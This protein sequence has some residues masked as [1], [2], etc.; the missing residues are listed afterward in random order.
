MVFSPPPRGLRVV[1]AFVAAALAAEPALASCPSGVDADGDGYPAGFVPGSDLD[2][3]DDSANGAGSWLGVST[4][5]GGTWRADL[6][7]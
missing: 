5:G 4:F 6:S 3:P 1:V 7:W 2:T